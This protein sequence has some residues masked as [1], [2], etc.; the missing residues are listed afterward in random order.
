MSRVRIHATKENNANGEV[1]LTVDSYGNMSCN[2]G[3]ISTT[4]FI[5]PDGICT[6]I[7]FEG[8]ECITMKGG[9]VLSVSGLEIIKD[10]EQPTQPE[11]EEE[12]RIEEPVPVLQLL[13]GGW[14]LTRAGSLESTSDSSFRFNS[15]T[16][17]IEKGY[18]SGKVQLNGVKYKFIN[19]RNSSSNG[20]SST[21][22]YKRVVFSPC[23]IRRLEING[24]AHLDVYAENSLETI[25][26]NSSGSVRVHA[27]QPLLSSVSVNSS[28]NVTVLR[29][30]G[31]SAGVANA[32]LSVNSSGSIRV[33]GAIDAPHCTLEVTS[34]GSIR[35]DR[36]RQA[37]AYVSSSG[38]ITVA[39]EECQRHIS[40][41]GK[42]LFFKDGR[43]VQ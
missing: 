3:N 30:V 10:N 11:A 28:G 5:G 7:R 15:E 8:G 34:S 36:A 25:R 37:E 23:Q 18:S 22:M 12:Q 41:T 24:N 19:Q 6:S 26:I 14:K 29:G 13:T 35:V 31:V 4:T 9:R 38:S 17:R 32:T 33:D 42:I 2:S 16:G 1:D 40:S 43:L 21:T 27:P 39:A 20:S